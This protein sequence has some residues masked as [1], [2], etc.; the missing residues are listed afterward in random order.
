MLESSF[1][2]LCLKLVVLEKGKMADYFSTRALLQGS[3]L[4]IAAERP[5]RSAAGSAA[6]VK[7]Q[8]ATRK[9]RGTFGKRARGNTSQ[10]SSTC[11]GAFS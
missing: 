7:P 4:S 3:S 5:T 6:S 11:Q 1:M 9:F 10:N 2:I 8:A